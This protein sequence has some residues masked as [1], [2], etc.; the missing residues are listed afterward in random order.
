M[1]GTNYVAQLANQIAA[2]G[3]LN[4]VA[5]PQASQRGITNPSIG[6]MQAKIFR[7]SQ[8]VEPQRQIAPLQQNAAPQTAYGRDQLA[9]SNE[10][11]ANVASGNLVNRKRKERGMAAE[12]EYAMQ[13]QQQAQAAMDEQARVSKVGATQIYQMASEMYGAK[14]AQKLADIAL[15][16]PERQPEMIKQLQAAIETQRVTGDERQFA[17]Q[18]EDEQSAAVFRGLTDGFG[19]DE[20]T[21][22]AIVHSD[23]PLE[24]AVKLLREGEK[25]TA[26][27][28]A[29]QWRTFQ[30]QANAMFEA[31]SAIKQA[32]KT[33]DFSDEFGATGLLGS[34]MK[35]IPETAAYKLKNSIDTQNAKLAFEE[36]LNMRR[37]SE[38]GG[39]LGNVSNR[40]IELLYRAFTVLDQG[41]GKEGFQSN[42]TDVLQRLERVKFM[43]NNENA[44]R[45][46]GML[47]KE[48]N[49]RANMYVTSQ[50]AKQMKTDQYP[51]GTPASAIQ[52]LMENPETMD[53][54]QKEFKW[55]PISIGLEED[56]DYELGKMREGNG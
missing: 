12:E 31:D 26:D 19:F 49:R 23:I 13:Q 32:N 6:A 55:S 25:L 24:N 45:E 1:A 50:V 2:K 56:Y 5:T 14:K 35:G 3:A 44:F 21:A 10:R 52:D 53:A 38:T 8:G 33:L 20:A 42:L 15:N 17:Q 34:L 47:P 43:I 46:E 11:H 30:S 48:M 27:Q 39:A 9:S 16:D 18:E 37:Q 28:K 51:N 36:L 7:P 4:K 41:I 29:L 40:E 22:D 54:F